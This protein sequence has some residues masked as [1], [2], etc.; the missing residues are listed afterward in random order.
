MQI[1]P[2][3]LGESLDFEAVKQAVIQYCQ[4]PGGKLFISKI[5]T[6]RNSNALERELIQ[7]NELLSLYLSEDSFPSTLFD[8]IK[9]PISRLKTQG[10]VL[11]EKQFSQIRS[12]SEC[13]ANMF[14]FV[15]KK[16]ERLFSIYQWIE[17]SQPEKEIAS[18]IDSRI[19]E[20]S[21]VKS[22]AS[23]ELQKIRARL[24]KSRAAADRIFERM[25]KKY[26]ERGVVADFHES[27]SEDRRV[28]AIQSTYK[29]QVSGIL[30][31]SSA[32]HSIT[33]IEPG[34]TVEINNEINF[35]LDEEKQEIRRILKELSD[36][37]RPFGPLLM[38]FENILT[39]LDFIKAKAIFAY[40]ENCCLPQINNKQ[41]IYLK[42]AYNPALLLV[43]KSK[44]K[45][46]IPLNLELDSKNRILV[47]SGP[48][49]GG[50]SI[51][52]KTLGLLQIMLQ[53]GF[54]IPVHP[55]S[56]MCL[57]KK[58]MGDIGDSQSI[59]NELSTYS[60]KLEKMKY[61]LNKADDQTLLLI[62]EFGSGSDP[63]LGS[64]LAQVFLER[65]NSYKTFGI[66]TTHYNSIKAIAA[67]TDGILNGAML[68]DSK[69]FNPE[70]RLEIGN[71]G[72]SYTFE[73]AQKTGIASF[74]I[75]E[76]RERTGKST[77][78]VDQLL[79][80]IQTDKLH[81]E[82]KRDQLNKELE[83]VRKL[84]S[85]KTETITKLEEKLN[86]QS[87]INEENDRLLYWGQRFQKLVDSWMD[88]KNQKDK[89]AV[90]ARFI[91][92]LNQRS[93][94]TE[95]EENIAL[96]KAGQKRKKQLERLISQ[97][98]KV[99]DK[100]RLIDSKM[101]G[102]IQEI[103]GEKYRVIVGDTISMTVDRNKIIPSSAKLE[104]P[105]KRK[106]RAKSFNAKVEGKAKKQK[107]DSQ[108]KADKENP[109]KKSAKS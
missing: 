77:I 46:T 108:K 80:Q 84:E 1:Y 19:D 14:R 73:V 75:K 69:T 24:V 45:A 47:I 36:C 64:A 33:Y 68:F 6:F 41:Y 16:R 92:L 76:A 21:Q 8:T 55:E 98:L 35:L 101:E 106:E 27:V 44:Q 104:T 74:I 10:S 11:E 48:N 58:L 97:E 5:S 62:D 90:V 66:F 99:G 51:A 30:H 100:V 9:D 71:P 39:K 18:E 109:K 49:A 61:F 22:N 70:Y 34:E 15:D 3:Q 95:K 23:P 38:D 91:G 29:G 37:I 57:F 85:E 82:K 43:N 60:S 2:H 65:L 17:P 4:T 78:K 28:L 83:Q 26:R 94:E 31:G 81:L 88:Q 63:D 40:R 79:V 12:L 25:L 67:S 96:S 13:Y 52:L 32:K 86:K 72:S 54:L 7:T 59:E 87:K 103:K 105:K 50:K 56:S 20:R 89:K 102:S 93:G 53:C 107:A 42:E